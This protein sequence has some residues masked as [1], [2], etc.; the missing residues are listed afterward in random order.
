MHEAIT[1]TVLSYTQSQFLTYL[2]HV[3]KYSKGA[4]G[5]SRHF[6]TSI[7]VITQGTTTGLKNMNMCEIHVQNPDT[8]NQD[9]VYKSMINKSVTDNA[10]IFCV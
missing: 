4:L 6:K 7:A 10:L 3:L 9:R 1:Q 8:S 5:Y 2:G